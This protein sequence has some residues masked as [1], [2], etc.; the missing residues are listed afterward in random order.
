MPS[1]KARWASTHAVPCCAPTRHIIMPCLPG[2]CPS[3]THPLSP[4]HGARPT[5]P[6]PCRGAKGLTGY[7]WAL[8]QDQWR[9][10]AVEDPIAPHGLKLP[11]EDYPFAHD[12]LI[13]WDS[14][15]QWVLNYFNHYYS[16]TAQIRTKSFKHGGWRSE[17]SQLRTVRVRRLLPKSPHDRKDQHA[18]KGHSK[19]V[20][21]KFVK[22]PEEAL[23]QCLPS[24]NQAV[25]DILSNHSQDEEYLGDQSEATWDEDPVIKAAFERFN[26]RLRSLK[27][28]LTKGMLT[29]V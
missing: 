15:K 6:W 10:L 28:S 17:P 20:W 12:G 18:H 5:K 13:L 11:I 3:Q 14:I 16:Y 8:S 26:G 7:Q 21:Q 27:A 25:L 9:G 24:Q 29:T 22:R 4:W 23:L 1:T 19:E 2:L